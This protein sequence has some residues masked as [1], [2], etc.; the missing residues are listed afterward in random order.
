VFEAIINE[1]S[2]LAGLYAPLMARLAA[3]SEVHIR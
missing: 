2:A 1:Q 3:G